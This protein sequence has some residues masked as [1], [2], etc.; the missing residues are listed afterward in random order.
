MSLA[1]ILAC[2]VFN[3]VYADEVDDFIRAEMTKR[4]I[5]GLSSLSFG[6]TKLSKWRAMV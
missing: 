3:P 5:P 1:W 4:K 2:A 6:T